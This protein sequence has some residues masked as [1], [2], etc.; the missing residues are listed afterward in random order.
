MLDRTCAAPDCHRPVNCR[1]WCPAHYQRWKKYGDPLAG[2]PFRKPRGAPSPPCSV[3]GC[4][5]DSVTRGWCDM[6]YRRWLNG[7]DPGEAQKRAPGAGVH[8]FPADDTLVALMRRQGSY[9]AVARAV[10]LS[11]ESLRDYIARRDEL[12]ARMD[13]HRAALLTPEQAAENNRRAARDYARRWRAANPDEARRVRREHMATYGPEYRHRWNHY[14]RL[15]RLEM[16]P[17]DEHAAEYAL[18]LRGDPCCYCGAPMRHVD[19]IQPI[20]RGGTGAWDNLT[21]ACASCNHRKGARP[22]LLFMLSELSLAA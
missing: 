3:S 22:L 12:R 17:P 5:R 9:N 7:G 13:A 16:V 20:A 19:H 4:A 10:G 6:H 18:I 1:G 14:N 21:A 11:R 15:R 2:P 8:G